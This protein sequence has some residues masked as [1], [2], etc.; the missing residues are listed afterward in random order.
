MSERNPVT[1]HEDDDPDFERASHLAR[2]TFR[3]FWKQVSL[4][5]N[6]IV[7]ALQVSCIKKPFSDDDS[8]PDSQV[9]HMWVSDIVFDG[10]TIR[11]VL[12]NAP[13]WLRSVS[14]G[15]IVE[16][17]VDEI[18]DWMCV[19]GGKVYGAYT[20]QATRSRMNE[21][22][23]AAYDEAWDLQ[24]PPPGEVLVPPEESDFEPVVAKL[25]NDNL[26][27]N[28]ESVEW[29]DDAGRSLLHHEALNGRSHSVR[30]LLDCGADPLIRC[31]RGWTPRDYANSLGWT[32]VARILEKA[33]SEQGSAGD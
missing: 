28:I 18:G 15:D 26:R 24:F 5:Y 33:E 17:T 4:D 6:R 30:V 25:L 27:K 16:C 14:E 13:N 1:F 22:E 9:E 7:P 32:G 31:D 19:L 20:V 12:I 23:R 8:D 3:Y 11:G 29:I 10:L 21:S 2:E